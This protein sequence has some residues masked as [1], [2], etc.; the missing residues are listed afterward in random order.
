MLILCKNMHTNKIGFLRYSKY[1]LKQIIVRIG[2]LIL[3]TISLLSGMRIGILPYKRLGH[4]GSNTELF[5]RRQAMQEGKRGALQIFVTSSQ[6]ANRQ[7]LTMIK[8]RLRVVENAFLTAIL[9]E[10]KTVFKNSNLWIELPFNT[11]EYY[12]FNHVSP[13]LAFTTEEEQRGKDL[14]VQMG[15]DS[16]KAFVCFHARDKSYLDAEHAYRSR[17]HWTYQDFKDC[18]ISNYVPA[19]E[20][21]ARQGMYALRMGA[22][23]SERLPVTNPL[24]I[25]YA[26][27]FRTDFGDVFLSAKC[28]FF[29]ASGSGARTVAY[30]FNVPIAMANAVPIG[31]IALGKQDLFIFKKYWSIENKRFLNFREIIEMG[32]DWWLRGEFFAQAG[33]ELIENTTDEILALTKEM[34]GRLDGTWVSTEEDEDLQ[35]RFRALFPPSHRCYGFPSRIGAEFLRQNRELLGTKVFA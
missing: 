17:E 31:D 15:I 5:L 33:I 18:D 11:N 14:L 26:N 8:R 12:E 7:L 25:D 10:T 6:V 3:K 2:F 27:K 4:L 30:L 35:R 23:V 32:A 21:L 29:L 34:V 16:G 9:Q 22:V 1:F 24:I 20:H 19:A 13:Q 28:K